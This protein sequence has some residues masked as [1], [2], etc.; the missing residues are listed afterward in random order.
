MKKR[1]RG[2]VVGYSGHEDPDGIAVPMMAVAKGAGIFERH[3]G[4]PTETISLNAYSMSPEQA[5]RWVGAIVD[6]RDICRVKKEGD[7][8]V[9]Q[10]ELDSLRSLSRGVFAR[11]PIKA[12]QPIRRGD[13]FF[14]MPCGEGQMASGE[15]APGMAAGKDYSVNEPLYE[16]KQYTDIN[17]ARGVIHDAKGLLFEAGIALGGQF[18]VELSHHYG[19]KQF[20]RTGAVI[21]SIIN[22]EYCKKLIVV[23][24]G[25]Q[26]PVHFHKVKE[27]T[28]QL[29]YGDLECV[30][31]GEAAQMQP[32]DTQTV[33]RNSKHSFSSRGG[34]VFEEISTTHVKG[35]SYYDDPEI[36]K[37][38]LMARKTIIKEW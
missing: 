22:R 1:Y 2:I 30:V 9:S 21:I 20:R 27:E 37:L 31:D 13:V 26:H 5:A 38:D 32:G 11:R 19:L 12:G 28:F 7:K 33:L 6:A 24:P 14:A 4:L 36:A 34:A 8:Y 15:F 29:L 17:L 16:K 25:Q 23:L 10:E 35:D 18:E 3:V